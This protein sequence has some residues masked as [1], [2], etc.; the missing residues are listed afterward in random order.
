MVDTSSI[1]SLDSG[2]AG[3]LSETRMTLTAGYTI[4]TDLAL[5]TVFL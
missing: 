1:E 2:I 4:T 5:D 3:F